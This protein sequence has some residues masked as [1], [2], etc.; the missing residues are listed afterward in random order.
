LRVK[1][2]DRRGAVSH[3]VIRRVLSVKEVCRQD[4]SEER[5]LPPP[6]SGESISGTRLAMQWI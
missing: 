6:N 4:H 2:R 1:E 5:G 3:V